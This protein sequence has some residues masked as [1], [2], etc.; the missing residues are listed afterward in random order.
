LSFG[1]FHREEKLQVKSTKR[2]PTA[3]RGVTLSEDP[4]EGVNRFGAGGGPA[5]ASKRECVG[6]DSGKD[7]EGRTVATAG[8]STTLLSDASV[9]CRT[10][11][12]IFLPSRTAYGGLG[13][14][15]PLAVGNGYL[16]RFSY[17]SINSAQGSSEAGR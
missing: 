5:W 13:E 10:I 15:V 11:G 17:I 6:S 3:A 2:W 14:S 4:L 16:L 9:I 1:E 8:V 12:Q 7:A